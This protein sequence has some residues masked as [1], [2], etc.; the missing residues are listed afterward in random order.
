METPI[1]F[2]SAAKDKGVYTVY[3]EEQTNR[4]EKELAAALAKFSERIIK[5]NPFQFFNFYDFFAE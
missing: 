5:I 4:D 1:Y 3:I 2:I